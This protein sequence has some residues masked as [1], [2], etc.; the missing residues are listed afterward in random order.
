MDLFK[1]QLEDVKLRLE[2]YFDPLLP[3]TLAGDANRIKQMLLKFLS[4]ACRI[5]PPEDG[6]LLVEVQLYVD[7]VKYLKISIGTNCLN[8]PIE[9][10]HQL[11]RPSRSIHGRLNSIYESFPNLRVCKQICE[12][13]GGDVIIDSFPG[14]LT[15]FVFTV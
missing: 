4:H 12:Q 10:Q 2:M 7:T 6:F 13:L 9:I 8:I 3:H 5:M 1:S 11:L 14:S 15:K